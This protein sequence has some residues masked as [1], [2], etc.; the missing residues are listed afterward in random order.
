MFQLDALNAV[1]GKA[2]SEEKLSK[3]KSLESY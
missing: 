2:I 3:R 1:K